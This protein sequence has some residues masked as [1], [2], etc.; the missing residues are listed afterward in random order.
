MIATA[1]FVDGE[2]IKG[3]LLK[4]APG[5]Q[6]LTWIFQVMP[7]H[8]GRSYSE[9]G[10]TGKRQAQRRGLR[11]WLAKAQPAIPPLLV[12]LSCLG[13]ARAHHGAV[14]C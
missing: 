2:L 3:H 5:T 10:V 12:L 4:D 1:Y 11:D 13:S 6:W 9:C 8:R 14:W 7:F